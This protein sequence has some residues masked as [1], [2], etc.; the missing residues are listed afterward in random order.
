[1]QAQITKVRQNTVRKQQKPS[2]K[3]MKAKAKKHTRTPIDSGLDSNLHL[4]KDFDYRAPEILT[5]VDL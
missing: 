2:E 3:K 1:M 5:E 4:V